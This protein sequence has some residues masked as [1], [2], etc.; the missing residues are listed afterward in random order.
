MDMRDNSLADIVVEMSHTD[1]RELMLE[2][3]ELADFEGLRQFAK[4][5]TEFSVPAAVIL[6]LDN[7]AEKQ[8][9]DVAD[10]ILEN[11]IGDVESDLSTL[12]GVAVKHSLAGAVSDFLVGSGTST[13]TFV[14]KTLAEVKA[15]LGLGSAAYTSSG[16]YAVSGKG[17]TNGDSHDH[18]GGDGAQID[19]GGLGGNDHDDHSQYL[20][21][22]GSRVL[23]A[24]WD[25]GNGRMIQ[26]DKIRARDGDG[27]ALF[28]DGGSGIFVKDGGN[29]GIGTVTPSYELDVNGFTNAKSN[30]KVSDEG[31]VL[32]MNFNSETI[33]GSA[34]S[35]TVLDSSGHNNHGT[36][37]GATHDPDGGF[38]DGG[39]FGYDGVNDYVVIVSG[40]TLDVATAA[41]SVSLW[42]K[43]NA[44]PTNNK[45]VIIYEKGTLTGA[46]PGYALG[47]SNNAGVFQL[48]LPKF[49]VAN[50]LYNWTPTL[51]VWYHIVAV[52][53]YTSTPTT[54]TFYV[55]G[56]PLGITGSNTSAYGNT[57]GYNAYIGGATGFT[58]NFDVFSGLIDDVRIY[59]RAL[60]ADEVKTLYLQ[61]AEAHNS[62][63]SQ[64]DVYVNSS[65]NIRVVGN[66]EI[67]GDLNHDGSNVGFYGT[68]PA[69]QHAAIA[70]ATDAATAITQLNLAL[71]TLRSL[72]LIAT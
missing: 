5:G 56:F 59:D 34:G 55:N 64:K 12:D 40:A 36:N 67:D 44:L 50:Q 37:V 69:V 2:I 26:T 53:N 45:Q 30:Y 71:A 54:V 7:K 29:V 65:G 66:A 62:Y 18:A 72:G 39:A 21:A 6:R 17:V 31:L 43:F 48:N 32:A 25:I 11:A 10:E 22:G 20:L 19:H 3:E 4:L 58:V 24:D 23:S 47:L 38:N 52:Q 35:E 33:T 16:D 13:F 27:L 8:A 57:A 1:K 28:E 15:I 46:S 63:V 49:G 51:G 42:I 14:K 41:Y 61:R 60:S 70:D 9:V 68:A